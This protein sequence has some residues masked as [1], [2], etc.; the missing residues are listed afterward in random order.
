MSADSQTLRTR[1]GASQNPDEAAA[2]AE[3]RA[4]IHQED[5]SAVLVFCSPR[6]DLGKLARAL[7]EA[8]SCPILACTSSGQLGATGFQLGG[9]SGASLASPALRA[10][11]YAIR[12]LADCQ[13]QAVAIGARIAEDRQSQPPSSK[14][15][16]LLLVDGL[17]MSEE[18]LVSALAHSLDGIPLVGGSAGDDLAFE[19]TYVYVDG[20]FVS[21][22]AVIGVFETTLPFE[23]LRFHHFEPTETRFVITRADPERRIVYE[24]DGEPAADVYASLVGA[25]RDALDFGVFSTHPMLLQ[26]GTEQYVRTIQRANPDGSLLLYCAIDEGLVL[27]IGRTVDPMS[28]LERAFDAAAKAVGRVEVVVGFDCICRRLEFEAT[29]LA[30][31]VGAFL[32]RQRVVG[33][34]TYGEQ[35]N[36]IHV[37]QTFTGVALGG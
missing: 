12:Q 5:A 21:G 36:G 27:S 29:G 3:L 35:Y 11:T 16:A 22:A 24:I 15:F 20:A 10:R 6:Y 1:H 33:F 7:R 19:R 32:A 4:Q 26:I 17:A 18:R 25:A 28:V 13:T 37:N 9:L 23:L 31:Q 2:V 34:S 8:F 14:A 30:P